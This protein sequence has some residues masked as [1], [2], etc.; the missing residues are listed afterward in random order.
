FIDFLI[1][2]QGTQVA[3]AECSQTRLSR[4]EGRGES[5]ESRPQSGGLLGIHV[6]NPTHHG[7]L[8]DGFDAIRWSMLQLAATNG[9][10]ATA[11]TRVCA[12]GRDGAWFFA[13]L[14]WS[15]HR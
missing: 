2:D 13:A 14:V 15:R 1:G 5:G 3:R 4:G 12:L 7:F 6:S 9:V 10:S 11:L 8:R